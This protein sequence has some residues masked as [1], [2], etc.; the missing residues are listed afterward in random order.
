MR[1]VGILITE[2]LIIRQFTEN[3]YFDLYEYLSNK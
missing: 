2:K 3:D 1:N